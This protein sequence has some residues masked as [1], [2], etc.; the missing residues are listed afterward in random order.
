MD[1]EAETTNE[2]LA[3]PF[4]VSLSDRREQYRL[5]W[6]AMRWKETVEL[7][8]CCQWED[9]LQERCGH[10][11]RMGQGKG[12]AHNPLS[13]RPCN[14]ITRSSFCSFWYSCGMCSRYS[15]FC[16]P[17]GI[18]QWWVPGFWA[19]IR[20]VNE[21]AKR[22]TSKVAR[23]YRLIVVIDIQN[24]TCLRLKTGPRFVAVKDTT[25]S[26]SLLIGQ[27]YL[28]SNKQKKNGICCQLEKP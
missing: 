6:H 14:M 19:R 20:L 24:G 11:I 9:L 28:I 16:W 26:G 22:C 25:A 18:V 13:E 17:D 21:K 27:V 3:C 7:A 8:S 15:R 12:E 2:W 10:L 1:P 4:R 5:P 23:R